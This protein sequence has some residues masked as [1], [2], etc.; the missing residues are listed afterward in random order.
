MQ[1]ENLSRHAHWLLRAALASVF[2]YHGITKFPQ[3]QQLAQMM[4]MPVSLILL[5]A[6]ME[7][8]GGSLVLFGGFLG[9]R[10]TR[11]GA[12]LLV[13]VMVGAITKV[14]WGQ[15]SFVATESHPMGGMEFQVTLLLTALFLL[16]RGNGT[17]TEGAVA[18]S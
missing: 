12:L 8:L 4:S 6:V 2:L 17:K 13:P 14:H 5:L 11:L 9:D 7:T 18:R 16:V 3:L 15:W 10:A 1:A